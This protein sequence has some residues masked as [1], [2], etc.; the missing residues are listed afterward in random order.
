[1]KTTGDLSHYDLLQLLK[2]LADAK[3]TGLLTVK[4][5]PSLQVWLQD[6]QIAHVQLGPV[7]GALALSVVLNDP[8]GAFAFD[9]GV[10]RSQKSTGELAA[11]PL[12]SVAFAALRYLQPQ[13]VALEGQVKLSQPERLPL[14]RLT[15]EEEGLVNVL[16]QKPVSALLEQPG[17]RELLWRLGRLDLLRER[18]SRLARLRVTLAQEK[19]RHAFVESTILQRWKEDTGQSVK[20]VLLRDEKGRTY[21]LPVQ[22]RAQLNAQLLV[23]ANL[24][25]QTGLR[26]GMSVLAQPEAPVNE[27]LGD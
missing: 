15:T 8:H 11:E 6:G 9:E 21:L 3:K 22:G 7:A 24:M 14:L 2:L 25:L 1:M 10:M 13:E 19:S 12:D 26:A 27:G 23:P 17:G 4:R 18:R 20:A 16:V 5:E